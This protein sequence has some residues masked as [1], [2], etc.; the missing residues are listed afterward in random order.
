MKEGLGVAPQLLSNRDK[1]LL[2]DAL[3]HTGA[4]LQLLEKLDLTQFLFLS[5]FAAAKT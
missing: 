1:T 3:K 5:L 4:L 2:V